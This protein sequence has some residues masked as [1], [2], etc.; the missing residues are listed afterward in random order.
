MFSGSSTLEPT[1]NKN[2]V[3][4]STYICKCLP[5]PPHSHTFPSSR[6]VGSDA[7]LPYGVQKC[8]SIIMAPVLRSVATSKRSIQANQNTTI[9]EEGAFRHR[10]QVPT[11]RSLDSQLV[12]RWGHEERTPAGEV[13]APWP[14]SAATDDQI[15]T[16]EHR[17][18]NAAQIGKYS[19]NHS[20]A[21]HNGSTVRSN[22]GLTSLPPSWQLY[23]AAS[24]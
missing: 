7:G 6:Q 11:G 18:A 3:S 10:P 2:A 4:H 15:T 17:P 9:M 19:H 23:V 22:G 8:N 21:D 20:A 16:T 14:K 24:W 13:A 5:P 1:I 12:R